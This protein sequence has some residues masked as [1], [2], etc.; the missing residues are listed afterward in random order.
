MHTCWLLWTRAS[1]LLLPLAA[2]TILLILGT[3]PLKS[4]SS[5]F[6][7]I[8]ERLSSVGTPLSVAASTDVS[9]MAGVS[10]GTDKPLDSSAGTVKPSD[11][12]IPVP[13][14]GPS[15]P[16]DTIKKSQQ[17]RSKLE[18]IKCNLASASL[19]TPQK[20]PS[21]KSVVLSG[22][23]V[24]I[25]TSQFCTELLQLQSFLCCTSQSDVLCFSC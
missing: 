9:I 17:L 2:V 25:F 18:H 1:A 20:P 8:D 21:P 6:A 14:G 11:S 16:E 22:A 23:S 15:S 24:R 4:A 12:S 5:L 13:N 19:I 7:A 3:P 10:A